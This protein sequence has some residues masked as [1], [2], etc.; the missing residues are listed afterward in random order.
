LAWSGAGALDQ[1]YEPSRWTQDILNMNLKIPYFRFA[2]LISLIAY[3]VGLIAAEREYIQGDHHFDKQ[4]FAAESIQITVNCYESPKYFVIAK[5]VQGKLGTDVLIKYRSGRN[6]KL[7]CDYNFLNSDFEIKSEWAE[8]FAGL[9]GDLLILDGT[10][11]PGPSSLTI[12]DLIKRQKVYEGSWSDPEETQ[13]NTLVFWM[14]TGKAYE[15]NCPKLKEWKSHGLEGAIET[16]VILNLSNFQI[17]KTPEI[18]C[19]PRQ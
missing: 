1:A 11:G 2:V 19:S 4:A 18:R 8:Y 3:P 14:E 17:L 10:T 16:K 13:N 6:E 5:E 7:S 15:D 9:K 12:W